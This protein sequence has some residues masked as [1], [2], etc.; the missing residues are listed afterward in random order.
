[1]TTAKYDVFIGL[2]FENVYLVGGRGGLTCGWE[3]GVYWGY[4]FRWGGMSKFLAGEQGGDSNPN[5]N[6]Y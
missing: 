5:I 2:Y 3:G 4:F 6:Q 1:M